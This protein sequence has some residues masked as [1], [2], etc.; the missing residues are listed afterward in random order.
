MRAFE[1]YEKLIE[2]LQE[3]SQE[4]FNYEN[5]PTGMSLL[6]EDAADAIQELLNEA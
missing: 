1:E 6:L 5:R 2:E 4:K 3:I